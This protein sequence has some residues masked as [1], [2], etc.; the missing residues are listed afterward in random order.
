MLRQNTL[1]AIGAVNGACGWYHSLVW[2]NA[3]QSSAAEAA[4]R[5]RPRDGSV[6][7][8][9]PPPLKIVMAL[10]LNATASSCP[11]EALGV[12]TVSVH[13]RECVL[14]PGGLNKDD[15]HKSRRGARLSYAVEPSFAVTFQKSQGAT[16]SRVVVVMPFHPADVAM[17]YVGLTRVAISS[18]MR[19]VAL[20]GSSVVGS[21]LDLPDRL[22]NFIAFVRKHSRSRPAE[23][24][25]GP[26]ARRPPRAEDAAL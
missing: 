8:D 15:A 14:V 24:R 22:K 11:L 5:A 20:L 26:P 2:E 17:L 7:V 18:G 25:V 13:G 10:P 16:F 4:V 3:A 1:A 12:V 23:A 21:K 9:V 6:F 19:W